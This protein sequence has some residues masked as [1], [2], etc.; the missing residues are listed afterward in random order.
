[1]NDIKPGSNPA[2]PTTATNGKTEEAQG[3][4]ERRVLQQEEKEEGPGQAEPVLKQGSRDAKD[5]GENQKA[6]PSG[7]GLFH[8]GIAR[9][10][11]VADGELHA[12]SS[13]NLRGG[14]LAE[15]PFPRRVSRTFRGTPSEP[16]PHDLPKAYDPTAIED[17]WAEYWVREKLFAQPTPASSANDRGLA[18]SPSP[19]CCR[20]P[21]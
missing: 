12:P 13:A 2:Q 20:R 18:A 10:P 8:F 9:A 1:M 4:L 19:S 3:R 14:P 16:M 5:Q 11:H 15:N 6:V 17:H 7:C 21:T